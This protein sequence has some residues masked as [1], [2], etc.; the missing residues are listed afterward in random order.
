MPS[1]LPEGEG[2]FAHLLEEK[3]ANAIYAAFMVAGQTLRGDEKTAVY[4][5]LWETSKVSLPD[6]AVTYDITNQLG[7]K[8][9]QKAKLEE[10]KVFH[11]AALEGRRRV[12]GD[13]HKKTLASLNNM[14]IILLKMENYQGELDYYQQALRGKGEG[15]GDDSS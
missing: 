7:I 14:V 3:S 10:A 11:L 2:G 15:V 9:V 13:E 6:E 4:R 1:A 12:L 8:L 5:R